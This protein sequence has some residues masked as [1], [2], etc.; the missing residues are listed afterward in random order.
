MK[1]LRICMVIPIQDRACAPV[2]LSPRRR[3]TVDASADDTTKPVELVVGSGGGSQDPAKALRRSG[4]QAGEAA[5]NDDDDSCDALAEEYGT[6]AVCC[7][8][9]FLDSGHQAH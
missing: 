7:S 2:H 8:N 6:T 3:K 9:G 5:R 4:W 1:G